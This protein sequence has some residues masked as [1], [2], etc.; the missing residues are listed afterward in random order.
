MG[1]AL[2]LSLLAPIFLVAA[3][4]VSSSVGFEESKN[5]ALLLEREYYRRAEVR[6]AM[7]GA[8]EG[9]GA[10]Q[11]KGLGDFLGTEYRQDGIDVVVWCGLV[12]E[13]ELNGLP[14]KMQASGA[15]ELCP[16]CWKAGE[17]IAG[18]CCGE[19]GCRPDEQDACAFFVSGGMNGTSIVAPQVPRI[20]DAGETC[21][22]P[23]IE[24]ARFK[25]A[26]VGASLYDR[27]MN[28]SGVV[29]LP[30]GLVVEDEGT[31]QR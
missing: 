18:V 20:T 2:V 26:I 29:V 23:E 11:L 14:Q 6:E 25:K 30:Q 1:A 28:T 24:A 3:M 15:A 7:L 21:E 19:E 10:A 22:Y 8:L 27:A 17:K 5:D 4:H 12:N 16:S 9:G 13:H 31:A